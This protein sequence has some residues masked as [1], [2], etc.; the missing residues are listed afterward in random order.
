MNVWLRSFT[1]ILSGKNDMWRSFV[2]A[3]KKVIKAVFDHTTNMADY[4]ADD[5]LEK[6]N[7]YFPSE[8]RKFFD[9]Q[10]SRYFHTLADELENLY[11]VFNKSS[12][13]EIINQYKNLNTLQDSWGTLLHYVCLM[14]N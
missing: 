3:E 13:Q 4:I 11:T 6:F 7:L 9:S 8:M 10:S 2:P 12:F 14:K 1:Y 5:N